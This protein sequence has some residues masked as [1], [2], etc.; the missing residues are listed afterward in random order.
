MSEKVNS[1]VALLQAG[2]LLSSK[3]DKQRSHA[4]LRIE[5][6]VREVFARLDTENQGRLDFK[7]FKR[8]IVVMLGHDVPDD[9]CNQHVLRCSMR[10]SLNSRGTIADDRYVT[11]N[12][13]SEVVADCLAKER[14]GYKTYEGS[15]LGTRKLPYQDMLL[16]IY[17][18]KV[19]V[20]LIAFLIL[21]NFIINITEK[22]IDPDP[23]N[24][25]YP[26]FFARADVAFNIIF[27]FELVANMWGYG[28]P[29]KAFW[30]SGWNVFDTI[31]V[32]VGVLNM[33]NALGPPLDKIKLMRAFRVFRLFKR[34]ESLNKI[35]VAL[36]KSIPGVTNAFIFLSIFFCIYAILAVELF[37]EFGNGGVYTTYDELSGKSATNDGMTTRG[38]IAGEEYYGTFMRALYT[39]FQVMTGESWSEAVA[40]PLLF[41]MY[42]SSAFTVGLFFVSLL[43]LMQIVLLNVVVA[44]LLEKIVTPEKSAAEQELDDQMEEL[45]ERMAEALARLDKEHFQKVDSIREVEVGE[46]S[47]HMHAFDDIDTVC[48]DEKDAAKDESTPALLDKLPGNGE[49]EGKADRI[50]SVLDKIIGKLSQVNTLAQSVA[51]LRSE[52]Q[53]IREDWTKSFSED[54]WTIPLEAERP[55]LSALGEESAPS[56]ES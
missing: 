6:H 1:A 47:E 32:L 17:N 38:F 22:Q 55:E 41:G 20:C 24:Q 27:L 45:D 26:E 28:G 43:I 29:V 36:F 7:E 16:R 2:R 51:D 56:I 13:F 9:I 34:V 48:S 52:M 39:L 30:L 42:K 49:V 33:V 54:D 35:I 5:A 18:H 12:G 4:N 44:V 40:R 53:D 14:V 23:E 19:F 8:A 15:I 11:L 25:K 37:R 10:Q 46:T 31:I 21:G 50:H 3:F